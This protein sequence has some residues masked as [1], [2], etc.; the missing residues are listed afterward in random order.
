[1][2]IVLNASVTTH[3]DPENAVRFSPSSTTEAFG[4][5]GS[6]FAAAFRQAQRPV[7]EPVEEPSADYGLT[8]FTDGSAADIPIDLF[9]V[10]RA[11]G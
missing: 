1:M 9:E 11:S 5:G 10:E 4:Q 2:L 3:C 8:Y 6:P 7:S